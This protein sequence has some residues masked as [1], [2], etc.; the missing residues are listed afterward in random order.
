MKPSTVGT[1]SR[2]S[3]FPTMLVGSIL[4]NV[5]ERSECWWQFKRIPECVLHGIGVFQATYKDRLAFGQFKE[6][7][8]NEIISFKIDMGLLVATNHIQTHVLVHIQRLLHLSVKFFCH[9]S[10]YNKRLQLGSSQSNSTALLNIGVSKLG[11]IVA[12]QPCSCT[13]DVVL[14]L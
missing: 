13:D 10:F 4:F 1:S 7:L 5:D 12:F 6:K 14:K 11:W 9:S 2:K 3:S 8:A